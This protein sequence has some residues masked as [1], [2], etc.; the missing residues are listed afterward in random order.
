MSYLYMNFTARWDNES[1]YIL[2]SFKSLKEQFEVLQRKLRSYNKN[3]SSLEELINICLP[4]YRENTFYLS[5]PGFERKIAEGKRDILYNVVVRPEKNEIINACIPQQFDIIFIGDIVF[6]N[7]VISFDVKGMELMDVNIAK[8]GE[9]EIKCKPA[10]AI[11]RDDKNRPSYN[12]KKDIRDSI[13]T[14]NLVDELC[15]NMYPVQNPENAIRQFENWEKY[16]KFRNYYI[17]HQKGKTFE[18]SQIKLKKAY[19]VSR[20]EYRQNEEKYQE[21]LLDDIKD[22][23]GVN[24]KEG[25]VLDREVENAEELYLLSIVFQG[26]RKDIQM[27]TVRRKNGEVT[28]RLLQELYLFTRN[29][30]A[31]TSEVKMEKGRVEYK[32]LITIGEKY[33]GRIYK[34]EI[35]PDCSGLE[36]EYN[37]EIEQEKKE[38]E[39][40]F[41]ELLKQELKEFESELDY[42][43]E[44][45]LEQVMTT[46]KEELNI[47]INEQLENRSDGEIEN[48]IKGEIK[49]IKKN[50]SEKYKKE[51]EKYEKDIEKKKNILKNI[52]KES[53][54]IEKK[55]LEKSINELEDR[56]I[57]QKNIIDN[58][59]EQEIT[60]IDIA[61]MYYTKMERLL[62]EKEFKEKDDLIQQKKNIITNQKSKLEKQYMIKKENEIDRKKIELK[63]E[64]EEKIVQKKEN[65]TYLCYYVYF[66][67]EQ[68]EFDNLK[69]KVKELEKYKMVRDSRAESKKIERQ[70]NALKALKQGYV[71][72]PFLSTYLFAPETLT[73]VTPKGYFADRMEFRIFK[74]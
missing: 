71:R 26:L 40:R 69:K 59:V 4:F 30:M 33:N 37:I 6:N 64:K 46:Y 3:V 20:E 47:K 56:L 67:L 38:I 63:K 58:E 2:E 39:S 10:C 50:I 5:M 48:R 41:D 42:E 34:K 68:N 1:K 65:E 45:K 61:K 43:L 66:L 49:K 35:E 70:E 23:N 72:N 54:E 55:S 13:L 12:V 28:T 44:N 73:N 8:F 21:Y 7:T 17:E 52:S 57:E 31:L 27:D 51:I 22:M 24:R 32:D 62:K 9:Y 19:K 18:Y 15:Q 16:L 60:K 74:R 11:T 29:P 14:Y 53:S 25:A 36:K